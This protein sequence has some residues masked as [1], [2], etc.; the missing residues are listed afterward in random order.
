MS[1]RTMGVLLLSLMACTASK[2]TDPDTDPV[3][4]T[5]TPDEVTP[6]PTPEDTPEVTPTD[7]DTDDSDDP[8]DTDSLDD[9][10]PSAGLTVDDLVPGDLI[11]TELMIDAD[12]C[13]DDF[14]EYVEVLYQGS[15]P[16]DLAGLELHD[17]SGMVTIADSYV[18]SPGEYVV[19]WRTPIGGVPQCYGFTGADGVSFPDTLALG[20]AGDRLE[21]HAAAGLLDAVDWTGWSIPIGQSLELDAAI[22]TTA[23]NDAEGA[24]CPASEAIAGH[25]DQGSPG[26]INPA[27]V[28]DTGIDMPTAETGFMHT[29]PEPLQVWDLSPGDLL[30]TEFM[31]DPD[32]CTD[33]SAEYIELRNE[34][35]EPVDL[36]DLQI[37]DAAGSATVSGHLVIQ[38][39]EHVAVHRSSTSP[40]CYGLDDLSYSGLSLNNGGDSIT[41]QYDDGAGSVVVFSAI[42]Y[43][44]W[45]VTTGASLQLDP[46]Q[47][48]PTVES[49][50]CTA[51]D[52]IGGSTDFG[53][54]GL[55]N[56]CGATD[57]GDTDTG[58]TDTAD[59]DTD[60]VDTDTV[61]TDETDL[62]DTDPLPDTG[63]TGHTGST[64]HT[65]GDTGVTGST[66]M[67]GDTGPAVPPSASYA[68]VLTE[69]A[70]WQSDINLRYIELT[71]VGSV[72]ASLTNWEL[73]RYTNTATAPSSTGDFRIGD[74]V[75][76]P[77]QT[78]VI[79]KPA[80]T[81]TF[82]TMFGREPDDT[83][84][85]I[86][87]NGDDPFALVY[88][89]GVATPTVI[90]LYGV[91][92][93]A[94]SGQ[95]WEY[96]DSIAT[97]AGTVTAPSATWDA[98]Q[99]SVDPGE[100]S[101][102]F[103]VHPAP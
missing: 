90:D 3:T 92:G 64:G 89:D 94:A 54:P 84:G 83:S 77:G 98:S 71:N 49:N 7:S 34:T 8:P 39:G 44:G 68:V 96:T 100:G 16:V 5:P 86:S 63:M 101:Q 42:D 88:N 80:G 67:T 69:I 27:C 81:G 41:L 37:A 29:G 4:P 99:W 51:P 59:T 52:L 66:G 47:T 33:G 30:L 65:G 11:I 10:G 87:G 19:L 38:P 12:E 95:P 57:T 62:P 25:T 91:I 18:A 15:D 60:T 35:L 97:R 36:F 6:T 76:A 14:A 23:G 28:R 1:S 26:A 103:G 21:L 48:D 70:D 31:A 2:D 61:D 22:L 24:W 82:T 85:V 102:S 40:Q 74:V 93:T 17:A 43:T 58:D 75:L 56:V 50:W 32:A 79:G 20:N 46:S 53:S 72:P 78:Y 55:A 13:F 45:T 73:W 9:T